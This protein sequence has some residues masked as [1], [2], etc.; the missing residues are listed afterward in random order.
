M[1]LKNCIFSLPWNQ[2]I[3]KKL[4]PS[5]TSHS[6]CKL[7]SKVI[8]KGWLYLWNIIQ[9]FY[10]NIIHFLI[11]N[12]H[13]PNWSNTSCKWRCTSWN[14][15]QANFTPDLRTI[16]CLNDV[17]PLFRSLFDVLTLGCYATKM[18]IK[19]FRWNASFKKHFPR[20][21]LKLLL[22]LPRNPLFSF[23]NAQ[24]PITYATYKIKVCQCINELS[25]GFLL[26]NKLRILT[27]LLG[28]KW[29][30]LCIY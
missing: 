10:V 25:N 3:G 8:F 29:C 20:N 4:G 21:S 15:Y 5:H 26:L 12:H 19:R 17:F 7:C 18:K 2:Y 6:T 28:K 13:F 22:R 23:S 27:F 24:F 30:L 16:N 1:Y 9:K 11:K 14:G